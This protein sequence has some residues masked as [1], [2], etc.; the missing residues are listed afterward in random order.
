MSFSKSC[1]LPTEVACILPYTFSAFW[2]SSCWYYCL[3]MHSDSIFIN[4]TCN[5]FY[6]NEFDTTNYNKIV[7]KN[8]K[9][10]SSKTLQ[11]SVSIT[12]K[13]IQIKDSSK[14]NSLQL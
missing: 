5:H 2:L 10:I 1:K 9:A 11:N 6:F 14:E 4:L 12:N 8:N 13:E 7:Q 3:D